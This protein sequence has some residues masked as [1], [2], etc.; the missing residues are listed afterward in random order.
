M[1]N[2]PC[3]VIRFETL[4]DLVVAYHGGLSRD[5]IRIRTSHLVEAGEELVIRLELGEAEEALELAATV[6]QTLPSDGPMFASQICLLPEAKRLL[7]DFIVRL[8]PSTAPREP[9]LEGGRA[10]VTMVVVDDHPFQRELAAAPFRKR[11]DLVLT[12]EDGLSGLALCLK[13]RPNV[14]LTDV[15]MPKVDGWQ[16]VRMIRAREQLAATPV[17]LFTTLASEKDRL[18]G[19]RLGVDDYLTKPCSAEVMV[20]RIDRVLRRAQAHRESLRPRAV[21]ALR[22]DLEHVGLPALL[23]FLELE[24]KSGTIR[25]EPK[26]ARV[27]VQR[28]RPVRAR[29]PERDS[30]DCGQLALLELLDLSTGRFEFVPGD[31]DESDSIRSSL[32]GILLEHARV[33]DE[34]CRGKAQG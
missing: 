1:S 4:D 29:T 25:L 17:V 5:K 16:L 9:G 22:G 18:L 19:Y 23:S 3:G 10:K 2:S 34:A 6:Q 15:Q 21:E 11:G 13:H 33:R 32:T 30:R 14:I 31:V 7:E 24:Q 8:D 26:G 27:V 28:G 20:A 12:A